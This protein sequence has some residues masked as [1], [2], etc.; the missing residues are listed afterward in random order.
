ML[1]SA[2]LYYLFHK[3]YRLKLKYDIHGA[4][5]IVLGLLNVGSAAA[6]IQVIGKLD[7]FPSETSL[8]A[9]VMALIAAVSDRRLLRR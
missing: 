7:S 8:A 2:R 3:P 1:G 5:K 9:T 6:L 4:A